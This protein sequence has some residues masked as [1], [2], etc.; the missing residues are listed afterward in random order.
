MDW[1]SKEPLTAL[2][3][4]L[5]ESPANMW[6]A[7]I[8]QGI[9][10]CFRRFC[11]QKL[12]TLGGDSLLLD[13]LWEDHLELFTSYAPEGLKAY[14]AL[15]FQPQNL[16]KLHTT[17]DGYNDFFVSVIRDI[18]TSLQTDSEEEVQVAISTFLD[19]GIRDCILEWLAGDAM[20]YMIYPKDE[21]EYDTFPESRFV[22]LVQSMILINSRAGPP[23][24]VEPPAVPLPP[25]SPAVEPEPEPE[26]EPLPKTEPKTVKAAISHRNKTLRKHGPRANHKVIT[27]IKSKRTGKTRRNAA[28]SGSKASS[29][30]KE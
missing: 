2:K 19:E 23:G 9:L 18:D 10:W 25:P 7:L 14:S 16:V 26:P 13:E 11:I 3:A 12:M 28:S 6:A 15:W 22:S 20:I 8:P 5:G 17:L 27:P 21:S 1:K 30:V 29:S 4:L 24:P